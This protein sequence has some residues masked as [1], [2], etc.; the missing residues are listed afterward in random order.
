VIKYQKLPKLNETIKLKA[1]YSYRVH[2]VN[3]KSEVTI[4]LP[5]AISLNLVL[6]QWLY[7]LSDDKESKFSEI[8]NIISTWSHFNDKDKDY[9]NFQYNRRVAQLEEEER[10]RLLAI[11]KEKQMN[12]YLKWLFRKKN[13]L[14]KESF[15]FL[16]SNEN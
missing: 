16:K 13:Y 9:I 5:Q 4:D 12:G 7:I 15:S 8:K 6:K 1:S 10:L 11:E 2:K 3:E 14:L